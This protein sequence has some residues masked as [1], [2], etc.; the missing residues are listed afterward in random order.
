MPIPTL[1]FLTAK[2]I[3]VDKLIRRT[4]TE[5]EIT[6]KLQRQNKILQRFFPAERSAIKARREEAVRSGNEAEVA[7]CDAELA[8]LE[9]PKLAFGTS[10][11]PTP[12]KPMEKGQQERLAE[13]NKRN[14]KANIEAVRKAQLRERRDDMKMLAAVARG[15]AVPD[16]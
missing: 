5:A 11:S 10:F 1:A 6:E 7:K 15:E 3:D 2:A 13:I 8:A 16:S 9:G 14:R 4:W 12:T